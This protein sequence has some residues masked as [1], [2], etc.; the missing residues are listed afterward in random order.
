M[1][2]SQTPLT[3]A[4]QAKLDQINAREFTYVSVSYYIDRE[5]KFDSFV[6][7][8]PSKPLA[9]QAAEQL[10]QTRL[11]ITDIVPQATRKNWQTARLSAEDGLDGRNHAD[12]H[13]YVKNY[14]DWSRN[15]VINRPQDVYNVA[16]PQTVTV[17]A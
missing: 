15:M 4:Q 8:T 16:A 11:G 9:R 2:K 7:L 13:L 14:I 10:V 6:V 17:A 5:L 1:S 3:T 12:I